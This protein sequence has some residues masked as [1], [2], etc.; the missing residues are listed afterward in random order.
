MAHWGIDGSL[1]HAWK[2]SIRVQDCAISP[3][4]RRLVVITSD[5]KLCMYDFR[6]YVEEYRIS[7]PVDLTCVTITRD[8]KYMLLSTGGNEIQLLDIET[9]DVVRKYKGQKQGSFVIRSSFGG[10]AENFVISGSEGMQSSTSPWGVRTDCVSKTPRSTFGIKKMANWW[11]RLKAIARAVSTRCLGTRETLV[12]S[13]QQGMMGKFACEYLYSFSIA[14]AKL[15][16]K[17][18]TP[19][20]CHREDANK[21]RRWSN[22]ADLPDLRADGGNR[23]VTSIGPARTSAVRSTFWGDGGSHL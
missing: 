19:S 21:S 12:F 15:S 4:G 17:I 6:T 16:Y 5:K 3:D 22:N 14:S 20:Y 1:R 11:K 18:H 7:F 10:A 8:G 13:P 9:T 2:H 23:S